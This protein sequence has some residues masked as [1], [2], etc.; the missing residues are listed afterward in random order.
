MPKND[1]LILKGTFIY[2]PSAA[3]FACHKDHY[4][5]AR[6]G[7]ILALE[8]ELPEKYAGLPV[9]D[10]SG[11]LLIPGFVDLHTHAA[12][13]RQRGLGLDLPLLPWLETYTFPE[14]QRFSSL[15][16]AQEIYDAFASELL[17]QGTT[18]VVTWATI[19]AESARLL[20]QALEKHGLG[21]YVGKVSMDRNCPDYLRENTAHALESAESFL[22]SYIK[23]PLVRAIVTPRF[24]PTCSRELLQGL[25]QLAERYQLPVQS[26][27][28]ENKEEISWVNE[29]FPERTGYHDVYDYYGLFGQM[30]TLMAHCVHLSEAALKC[31]REKQV[32]A[33]HCPDSNLNLASGIMQT[34]RLLDEGVPVGLGSDV[35]AGH[36]FSMPQAII[37]AI[38]LSK[39]VFLQDP[40]QKPLTLSEAFYLATKEGGRFFGQVGS[41]EAGFELDALVL[42][43]ARHLQ[44]ATPLEQLQHFLYTQSASAIT[45]RYIAGQKRT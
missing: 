29:L 33:V 36:T 27:L 22:S 1:L 43:P 7:R 5:V 18:R 31:M 17:L 15:A 21:A 14:E 23:G 24:A 10:Y 38:Q 6:H 20:C 35:G 11:H 16:Y 41:F 40:S 28:S 37:R 34:R 8:P 3:S 13:F 12:Q 26:H 19:H 45:T 9:A 42:Q 30:P 4:L 2:T 44:T 39:L 25:G 32:F